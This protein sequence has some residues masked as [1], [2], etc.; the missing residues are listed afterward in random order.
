MTS[1]AEYQPL[2]QFQ[3]DSPCLSGEMNR[4]LESDSH[5][6]MLKNPSSV[7]LPLSPQSDNVYPGYQPMNINGSSLYSNPSFNASSCEFNANNVPYIPNFDSVSLMYQTCPEM[8]I[9]SNSIPWG[10][11]YTSPQQS[12]E[13]ECYQQMAQGLQ[14]TP[15]PQTPYS[16][17]Y[18]PSS[19]SSMDPTCITG[20]F[21]GSPVNMYPTQSIPISSSNSVS[22]SKLNSQPTAKSTKAGKASHK[23]QL[24]T[25]KNAASHKMHKLL[26]NR[27]AAAKCR[28]KKKE[29]LDATKIKIE[30][31]GKENADLEEVILR[32]REDI[33]DMKLLL[34]NI[35]H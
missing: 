14:L 1:F 9:S 17:D 11:L 15:L 2:Y 20:I 30:T 6:F 34:A 5:M 27:E 24:K 35:D 8:A 33:V 21:T 22:S 4:Q 19:C 29:Y 3:N 31:L 23:T 32:L 25:P 26:R 7:Q 18:E 12:S 16:N 13:F 10:A 28:Q